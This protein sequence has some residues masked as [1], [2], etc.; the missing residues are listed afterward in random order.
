M[1]PLFSLILIAMASAALFG[2]VFLVLKM[3]LRTTDALRR[4]GGFVIG[5]GIG[6]TLSAGALALA[7][8]TD[9]TLTTTTQVYAYLS[10]VALGAL[11]GGT[12]LSCF[13]AWK[14]R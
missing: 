2:V 9:V 11:A 5:T 13:V 10:A 7:M 1:G 8:G 6:A 12:A 3:F 14:F 4:A